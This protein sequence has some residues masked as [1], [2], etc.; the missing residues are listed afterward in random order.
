MRMSRLFLVD[1][2][3]LV[4][5]PPGVPQKATDFGITQTFSGRLAEFH[6]QWDPRRLFYTLDVITNDEGVV[7]VAYPEPGMPITLRGFL[8]RNR[9][10][11]L[12]LLFIHKTDQ[13]VAM[14]PDTL[15]DFLFIASEGLVGRSE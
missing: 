14:T 2:W 4:R 12:E 8:A 3:H 10:R 13:S 5:I 6:F 7:K 9:A 15:Q 1:L 11:D